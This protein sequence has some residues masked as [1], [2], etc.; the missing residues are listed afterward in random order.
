MR[1]LNKTQGL[2]AWPF[3][4]DYALAPQGSEGRN[5][6]GIGL[7]SERENTLLACFESTGDSDMAN[8]AR[9]LRL[10]N[11]S[12]IR[13][14]PVGA[15]PGGVGVCVLRQSCELAPFDAAGVGHAD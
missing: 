9:R 15:V 2:G 8:Q 7:D 12:A 4:I 6:A 14:K 5:P 11:E 13:D 3:Y 10:G 1:G